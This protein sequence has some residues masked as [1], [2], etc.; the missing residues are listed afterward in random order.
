MLSS[1]WP[2]TNGKQVCKKLSY[3]GLLLVMHH[4]VYSSVKNQAASVAESI[5]K[6]MKVE[7]GDHMTP[8]LFDCHN[9]L[10]VAKCLELHCRAIVIAITSSTF[11]TKS[12][13]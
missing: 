1:Q 9:W 6:S 12:P 3:C 4:A 8:I 11:W 10:P 13:C 7:N 2:I 5:M